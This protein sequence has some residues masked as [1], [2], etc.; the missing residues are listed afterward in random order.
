MREF[1]LLRRM[2]SPPESIPFTGPLNHVVRTT[3]LLLLSA[4]LPLW[5]QEPLQVRVVDGE[6][7]VYTVGSR[8]TRGVTVEVNDSAGAPVEGATVRFELPTRG[9]TGTFPSGERTTS[10][11]T[12]ADGRAEAWGMQWNR[13]AGP[14]ELRVTASK[15][16]LTATNRVGLSLTSA[17]I[18][19]NATVQDPGRGHKKL[20]IAL[21]VVGAAGAAVVG[22][23]GKT[24][25]SS[26]GAAPAAN[27]PQIGSP[28]I[29]IGRP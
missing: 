3:V 23:A 13:E 12:G 6:G 15:G 16:A 18:P 5:G 28:S 26:S 17:P 11:T 19:V 9:S 24:P 4:W 10:V 8:A 2:E 21:V 20:W 25:S 27:S 7:V 22:L 1:A 14:L 29:T